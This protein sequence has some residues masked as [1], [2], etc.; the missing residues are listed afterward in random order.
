ML[1]VSVIVIDTV[2]LMHLMVW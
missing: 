1:K 2:Y